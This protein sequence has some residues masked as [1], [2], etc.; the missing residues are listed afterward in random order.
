LVCP[1]HGSEFSQGGQVVRGPAQRALAKYSATL[2]GSQVTIAT[3]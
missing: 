3:G 1:C 2:V